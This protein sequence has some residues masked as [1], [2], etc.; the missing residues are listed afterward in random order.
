MNKTTVG[1]NGMIYFVIYPIQ[2]GGPRAAEDAQGKSPNG[3]ILQWVE[4]PTVH[5]VRKLTI[6][7]GISITW[8]WSLKSVNSQGQIF[9][10]CKH[11]C[12]VYFVS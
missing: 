7:F 3:V 1:G 4:K 6:R 9:L 12:N 8:L 10:T 11:S 5:W 2:K